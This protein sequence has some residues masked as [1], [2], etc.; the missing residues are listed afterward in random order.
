MSLTWPQPPVS[1]AGVDTERVVNKPKRTHLE[2]NSLL[3]FYSFANLIYLLTRPTWTFSKNKYGK[4]K[5]SCS[6]FVSFRCQGVWCVFVS[7]NN[8]LWQ[9]FLNWGRHYEN[10]ARVH[11]AIEKKK[12][13]SKRFLTGLHSTHEESS[14]KSK[15][16]VYT[17][18]KNGKMD[19]LLSLAR[20]PLKVAALGLSFSGQG[21]VQM[22]E[23]CVCVRS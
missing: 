6:W 21:K 11:R 23:G 17:L 12:K 4:N 10:Q 5:D 13:K 20:P 7:K 2:V 18:E 1:S 15:L 22:D 9:E 14:P 8:S 16:T 3:C 19:S